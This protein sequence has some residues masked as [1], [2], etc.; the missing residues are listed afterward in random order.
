MKLE[1]W[2]CALGAS[3]TWGSLK[4]I[5]KCHR[6]EVGRVGLRNPVM[7][8]P[9]L[10]IWAHK[11]HTLRAGTGQQVYS[12]KEAGS[13]LLFPWLWCPQ[14]K[15]HIWQEVPIIGGSPQ[16]EPNSSTQ[17]LMATHPSAYADAYVIPPW[18][19]FS[20]HRSR[21]E[22]QLLNLSIRRWK[23]QILT[24]CLPCAEHHEK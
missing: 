20:F 7:A 17:C 21:L 12:Q 5:L 10:I 13:F 23:Q 14:Q 9:S 2:T 4:N 24:K 8:W 11:L 1:P 6:T 22:G 3:I 16:H 15:A 18:N 19:A